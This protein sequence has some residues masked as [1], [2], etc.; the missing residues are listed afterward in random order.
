[1][2]QASANAKAAGAGGAG[3]AVKKSKTI[4]EQ[5]QKKTQLEHILLRPDSYVGSVARVPQAMWVLDPATSRIAM[6]M[7][8]Y[9]PGLYKIFDEILVNAADNKQRDAAMSQLHITIDAGAGTISVLNNGAGIPVAKHAEHGMWVPELIFGHLLTSSNYDDEEKKVTGGRNGYGAKLANIFSTEFRVEA[10][11]G[12]RGLKLTQNWRGNMSSTV[13]EAV[14]VPYAG[15]DFVRV[16]FRPD[17][18]RFGMAALDADMV[19]LMSRRVYDMAGVLG[20][21]VGVRLNGADV[22][23]R[24]WAEYVALY[25]LPAEA[26][27]GG[28]APAP[29]APRVAEKAGPR[30]EVCA[31]LS[32]GSFGSVSFVNGIYT[33][34]GGQHVVYIADKIAAAVAEAAN[35]KNKGG[36]EINAATVRNHLFLWVNCLV[37]NPAFD[38]QTKDTLTTRPK[39][40][41]SLPELSDKF[42]KGIIATGI[43]ERVLSWAQFKAVS[44]LQRMA[45]GKAKAGGRLL[46]LPKLDEAN[47]AGTAKG[48]RATL[49]LTEGD[50]AKSLAIAGLSVVGRD[51][52]GVFPLKGKLL[53]VREANHKSIMANAEIQAIV[54]I[55]GL[56]YGKVYDST[57]GLRYGHLMIMSDQD[58]D[59]SHIKGLLLN[60]LHHF[61]PSLLRLPGFLQEF[62]TPIV[63]AVR[64]KASHTFFTLPQY[65]AWKDAPAPAGGAGGKGW[66]I[67][68]YKGL[69]T[70]T[71][72][73]AK[74]YFGDLGTHVLDFA[75]D[76]PLETGHDANDLIDLAFSKKRA[77]DRK[78]WLRAFEPGTFVDYG[79]AQMLVSDF[80]HKELILFSMADNVR[81][82]PCMLDGL[83]PAQRKV[84]FACFKRGLRADIKV[85]QLAGYVSEHAAYHHGEVSL[86]GT[87]VGMAQNFVGSN[88]INLLI[89]SGQF[90][91]RLMGG[92]DAASARYIF[93][94]LSPLARAIY[95]PD[96]DAL[97]EH[98][99]DDGV[100][101][102]PKHYLPVLPMV[103]INGAEG[104]GTGWSTSIPNHSPKDVI[105][106]LRARIAGEDMPPLHPWYRG[107]TGTIEAKGEGA[108]GGG[109]AAYTA[110]G[111]AVVD[112]ARSAIT[113]TELPVGKWTQDYKHMLVEM[114][115]GQKAE[116][117]AK[118]AGKAAG[119]GGAGGGA[120]GKKKAVA[121]AA[122]KGKGGAGAGAAAAGAKGKGA[123]G[124]K[125]AGAA[126]DKE[127][128][129]AVGGGGSAAAAAPRARPAPKKAPAEQLDDE[130]EEDEEGGADE[131]SAFESEE[132]EEEEE[133]E[134]DDGSGSD[135]PKRKAKKGG[136]GGGGG[137]KAKKVD[138]RA[139]LL[140]L[141]PAAG[142]PLIKDFEE[143]H[144]D[145]TVHFTL[146]AALP[147]ATRLL[148][149]CTAPAPSG[150]GFQASPYLRR[151][152]RLE[153][154]ISTANMH[155]FDAQGAIR[156]YANTAEIIEGACRRERGR[157]RRARGPAS[158]V[159]H[160]ARTSS[161]IHSPPPCSPPAQSSTRCACRL[162]RTARRT[163]WCG[164]GRRLTAAPTSCAS[165]AR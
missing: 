95:H 117:K 149:T 143:G 27:S 150:A 146:N 131:D 134:D 38:S 64:G 165:S 70:S 48:D 151:A 75:M 76:E 101:I 99:D 32:D 47:W 46:D 5:Y 144:T 18:A 116:E 62:I 81:S 86:A 88:N 154:S 34:W 37:D 120:A 26:A 60:F 22:P 93:T 142:D 28:G 158:C 164:W 56:T 10:A 119:K 114:V 148:A 9:V 135:A 57:K 163:C 111:T 155:L 104:I 55:M 118:E 129:A 25:D 85:A 31:T 52:Y 137:G 67:K 72:L 108:G 3:A 74:E 79:V 61:W 113:I 94:R 100:S 71:A 11:D 162:T 20:K 112:G 132:E 6:R 43:V 138:E 126:V 35:K 160:L 140:A 91:T 82:I 2:L 156:R 19:A 123:G 80:I 161:P 122:A 73:E 78:E 54:K 8:S 14:V 83:K 147:A 36:K 125:A 59:G 141:L 58:H 1:M 24:S 105:A 63:K 103:L 12:A 21:G 98:L 39:D 42:M 41:G 128:A 136:A 29:P 157:A 106:A 84:L 16:T 96:D 159:T 90:G 65:F 139:A 115:T 4:E 124:K 66:A 40:F 87:I 145:T 107:F 92:K 7:V 53:N 109:P 152:L 110:T 97:L 33:T 89:P 30:W 17:L 13:G 127:N 77:D 51:A 23:V 69:G 121:A 133:D 45:G 50:S 130:E 102:E 153:G 49:I 44:E 15:A 68:Y